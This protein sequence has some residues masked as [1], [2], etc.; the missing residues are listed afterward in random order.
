MSY[1]IEPKS[2]FEFTNDTNLQLP[3]FQRRS[4]W[5]KGQNFELAI[6]I[7]QD[8]PIG[9]VVINHEKDVDWLLDGRQRR[10]A[11]K[12]MRENPVELYDWAKKYIGFNKTADVSDVSKAYWEKVEKY[13][14]TETV[15]A[16]TDSNSNSD[17]VDV[18][19]D[20]DDDLELD[21]QSFNVE[22]QKEGLKTLLSLILMVHQVNRNGI[23]RWEKL[24]DFTEYLI[25][26]KYAPKKDGE[27]VD[28]VKLRTFLIDLIQE[29]S[30][31]EGTLTEDKFV[32][33]YLEASSLKS[34]DGSGKA[35]KRFRDCINKNWNEIESSLNVI[36]KSEKIFSDARIGVI[37]LT[38][39]TPLDAQIIFSRIN[40]NGTQLKAEELLSAKPY[41][42]I[43]VVNQSAKV[44]DLVDKLYLKLGVTP[45]N[46]IVRWDLASTL[47]QRIDEYNLILRS[48]DT[49][50]NEINM[51]E[52]TLGF[53]LLSSI[54]QKGMNNVAVLAMEQSNIDWDNDI[55]NLVEDLNLIIKL[56]MNDSFFKYYQ[57]WKKPMVSL[58]GTAIA[59]EF[60]TVLYED[61]TSKGKP[62][63]GSA[64]TDAFVRD[65]RILFDRLVYE[66]LARM[67]KGSGDNKM[68][69][70]IK[71]WQERIKPVDDNAWKNL[72]DGALNG[73]YNGQGMSQKVVTPALYYYYSLK[74][75]SPESGIT[76]SYD[77]DHI[78]PQALFK[79]NQYAPQQLMDSL[80][81]LALLP[82][83]DN[84]KKSDNKLNEITDS[85][86][87]NQVTKYELIGEKDFDKYSDITNIEDLK[88][89]R[90]NDIKD[91]FGDK[92]VTALAK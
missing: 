65:A 49:V 75:N 42:N 44:K 82:K 36:K 48:L 11:L 90:G 39:A 19:S 64:N 89:L 67:W 35:E 33:Y 74:E 76:I 12:V 72:I 68:S 66:H 52:V 77:V 5:K 45:P 29:T 8:Y 59:L 70:D 14:Q 86:L 13:L 84:I 23:S 26:L 27:K 58:L 30:K 2:V 20:E 83:K 15:D 3:R 51:T 32:E 41:W 37:K 9:V 53:K 85:W 7:F 18:Y 79:G 92:R 55:E 50:N 46:E 6:S 60:I 73:N 80:T 88:K 28:P 10:N 24:F 47:I 87:K 1:Q 81:N 4:V 16:K 22:K 25:P 54:Y 62:A 34:D 31:T 91:I 71:H 38:R 40:K 63:V 78:Y 21:E 57:S 69:K 61:W 43:S 56:I 17:D